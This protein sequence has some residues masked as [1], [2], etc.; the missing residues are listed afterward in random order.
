M[1]DFNSVL[2]SAAHLNLYQNLWLTASQYNVVGDQETKKVQ[3]QLVHQLGNGFF[4]YIEIHIGKFAD[5]NGCFLLYV[6]IFQGC[7]FVGVFIMMASTI[8]GLRSIIA[9]ASTYSFYT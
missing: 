8:G 6:N 3:P 7:I 9:D 4:I 1:T 2:L 5:N